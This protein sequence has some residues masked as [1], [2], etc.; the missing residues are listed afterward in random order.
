MGGW[1]DAECKYLV[2]IPSYLDAAYPLL[3]F[4]VCGEGS[5]VLEHMI[6]GQVEGGNNPF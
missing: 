3:E 4:H 1:G 6:I 2:I 5:E